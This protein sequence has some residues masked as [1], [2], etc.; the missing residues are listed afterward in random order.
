MLLLLCIIL[1]VWLLTLA[2]DYLLARYAKNGGTNGRRT[3]G[4]PFCTNFKLRF[5]YEVSF[6]IVLCILVYLSYTRSRLSSFAFVVSILAL[7][8]LAA[9][10]LFCMSLGYRN[11]PYVRGSFEKGTLIKSFWAV[12]PIN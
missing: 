3:P 8:G 12:R 6:E 2:K 9:A 10:L 5:L 4:E 7:L 1:F 11:G